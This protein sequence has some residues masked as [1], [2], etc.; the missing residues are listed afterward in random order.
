[1]S[2]FWLLQFTSCTTNFSS[3]AVFFASAP[4]LQTEAGTNMLDKI[5]L[6][7]RKLFHNYQNHELRG[8]MMLISGILFCALPTLGGL[9]LIIAALD[10]SKWLQVVFALLIIATSLSIGLSI[11]NKA[12]K[13]IRTI[14]LGWGAEIK[15]TSGHFLISHAEDGA[16]LCD[17]TG[18][19]LQHYLGDK[20]KLHDMRARTFTIAHFST[21]CDGA[22]IS[23]QTS[24][25]WRIWDL[26]RYLH[27]AM[28]PTA[29]L[30]DAVRRNLTDIIHRSNGTNL[31]QNIHQIEEFVLRASNLETYGICIDQVRIITIDAIQN[32]LP[33]S[34]VVNN[35][36]SNQPAPAQATQ[37]AG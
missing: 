5:D 21:A 7:A 35:Q 6:L 27:L 20:V 28:T 22:G 9:V 12:N 10:F 23:T 13:L 33:L 3:N 36:P 2:G 15:T 32:Q 17:L 18:K 24:V 11:I 14:P 1:L 19:A 31:A 30:E 29:I 25:I 34:P 4:A 26:N 16:W 37:P 8:K